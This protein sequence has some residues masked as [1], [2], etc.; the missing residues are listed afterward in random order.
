MPEDFDFDLHDDDVVEDA[1]SAEV[2][3]P[4]TPVEAVPADAPDVELQFDPDYSSDEKSVVVSVAG[5]A[6]REI[7]TDGSKF[8]VPAD[9]A[10]LLV[11]SPAVKEVN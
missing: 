9:E 6:P 7:K 1:P 11:Q 3:E 5:L 4:E 8:K 2:P 10:A